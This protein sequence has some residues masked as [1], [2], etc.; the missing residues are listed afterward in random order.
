MGTISVFWQLKVNLKEKIYL[1]VNS[2]T[3]R[4]PKK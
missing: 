1:N 3:Q 2:T 4:W